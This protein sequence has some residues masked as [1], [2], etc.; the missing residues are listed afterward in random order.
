MAIREG[1]WDCPSCGRAGNRGPERYCAGCG[2]PR[3]ADVRFYLPPEAAEVTD[4]AGLAAAQTGPDWTCGYCGGDNRADAAHCTQC[5]AGRDGSRPRPVVEHVDAAPA[6]PSPAPLA[7]GPKKRRGKGCA[8]VGLALAAFVGLQL[9]C[10]RPRE[11]ALT[12][13]GYSWV[14]TVDVQALR[15]VEEEG[16]E[17]EIPANARVISTRRELYRTDR[18][19][20]GTRQETKTVT[21][22][23]QVGTERVKTG[24]RDLGN[25]YFEDIYED[26]PVYRNESRRVSET[27]PVYEERKVY[28]NRLRYALTKWVT[29]RTETARGQGQEADWPDLRLG[30]GEQTGARAETYEVQLADPKGRTFTYQV[31]SE[32]L[33]RS[34][35]PG[36]RYQGE[37]QG[38]EVKN[39][40]PAGGR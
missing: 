1:R 32:S 30:P 26:R 36:G 3:G 15:P 6:P 11:V 14:R 19:Q 9:W 33:F 28:K 38:G 27:V 2:A 29:I 13:V 16:W 4:A 17:G 12:P 7:L 25:G 31:P 20:V 34:L 5:G 24:S 22:R 39:L 21:E 8:I 35:V 10:H 37:L 23:V 40:A 18:V